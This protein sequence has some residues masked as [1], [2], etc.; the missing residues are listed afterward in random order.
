M[1][2]DCREFHGPSDWGWICQRV[3][4]IRCQDTS[5]ITFVDSEKNETVAMCVM[6]NW[7]PNSVQIHAAALGAHVMREHHKQIYGEVFDYIFNVRDKKHVYAWMLGDNDKVINLAE[8][9]GFTEKVRLPDGYADGIDFLMM[10]ISREEAAHLYIPRH[11]NYPL[12]LGE[13]GS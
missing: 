2:L 10:G 9:A 5:G 12:E 3:G 4:M 6:D 13:V 1:K 8:R 7:M 11:I